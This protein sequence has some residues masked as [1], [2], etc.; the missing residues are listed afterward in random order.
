MPREGEPDMRDPKDKEL[1]RKQGVEPYPVPNKS[2]VV[3]KPQADDATPT[4][5]DYE[6][7]EEKDGEYLEGTDRM[8]EKLKREGVTEE[9]KDGRTQGAPTKKT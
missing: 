7:G 8:R 5:S 1:H 4:G 6:S 2:K 9:W 3:G